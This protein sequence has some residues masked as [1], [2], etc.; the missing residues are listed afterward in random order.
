MSPPR[1]DLCAL[2]RGSV[3]N[4][5]QGWSIS[6][7]A[8]V[9]WFGCRNQG[10]RRI[11]TRRVSRTSLASSRTSGRWPALKL[12]LHKSGRVLWTVRGPP[13]SSSRV[14][15]RRSSDAWSVGQMLRRDDVLIP[16]KVSGRLV[17]HP[18][19]QP[20]PALVNPRPKQEGGTGSLSWDYTPEVVVSQR[21]SASPEMKQLGK[22]TI[23]N[24]HR[25]YRLNTVAN[26]SWVAMA[27]AA[28]G[29][30]SRSS[31]GD[32]SLEARRSESRGIL[33]RKLTE[34]SDLLRWIPVHV[35][36]SPY[37]WAGLLTVLG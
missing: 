13:S 37:Q 23:S 30:I 4:R 36:H 26:R 29:Y 28:H 31:A 10:L 17:R 34:P 32:A 18:C 8:A 21:A 15:S 12:T 11:G 14:S 25:T 33:S 7:K 6:C 19:R 1:C 24:K 20:L 35:K 2:G 27:P 16:R 3:H 9:S 22:R 5:P